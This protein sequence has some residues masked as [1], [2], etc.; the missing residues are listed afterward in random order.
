MDIGLPANIKGYQHARTAIVLMYGDSENMKGLITKQLYPDV[1]KK[2]STTSQRVEKTIRD[3]VERVFSYGD[4]EIL[5]RYFGN[6]ILPT[7]GKPTNT[8]FLSAI[9]NFLRMQDENN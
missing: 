3:A 2:Y 6:S 9:V 4:M 1:A 5:Q 7:K 8:E